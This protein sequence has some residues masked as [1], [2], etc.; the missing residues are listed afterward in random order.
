MSEG[1][2]GLCATRGAILGWLGVVLVPL[3][4]EVKELDE[5]PATAELSFDLL[6]AVPLFVG[7]LVLV[8]GRAGL[9]V[10]ITAAALLMVAT[11]LAGWDA[12]GDVSYAGR[13]PVVWAGALTLSQAVIVFTAGRAWRAMP[14]ATGPV[15]YVKAFAAGAAP[16]LVGAGMAPMGGGLHQPST[17]E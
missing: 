12:L 1:R 3:I 4:L 13:R 16:L 15:S 14:K 8:R 9:S 7:A 2:R 11:V 5:S 6:F 10:V 17:N